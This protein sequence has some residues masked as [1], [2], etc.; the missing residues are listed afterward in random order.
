MVSTSASSRINQ[1]RLVATFIKVKSNKF[2]KKSKTRYLVFL[3]WLWGAHF[4]KVMRV[5]IFLMLLVIS[6]IYANSTY[7]QSTKFSL[8]LRNI[9]LGQLFEEIQNQS[10][11]NIFYNDSQVELD[12]KITVKVSESSVEEVLRQAFEGIDLNFYVFEKQI[13]IFPE[14]K[15][16]N[17]KELNKDLPQQKSVSGKVTD[18]SGSPLPGVTVIVKGST[19]GTISDGEGNFVLSNVSEDAILVFSFIGMRTQEIPVAN[20]SS[21]QKVKMKEDA[22][23]IEEV[24]AVGYGTMK[25]SDVTGA[26]SSVS[27]SALMKSEPTNVLRGV[28]GK[29][30]GVQISQQD[31]APG[32]GF[33]VIIRG[34]NSITAGS[35][36]LYIVDGA[37]FTGDMNEIDPNQIESLEVLKDASATAVYGA[38]AA[39]G[40]IIITTK[41]GKSGENKLD[42]QAS[43]GLAKMSRTPGIMS[44]MELL[45]HARNYHTNWYYRNFDSR[46]Q[47]G[48]YRWS[49]RNEDSETHN[50]I[51]E[52]T[53]VAPTSNISANFIHGSENTNYRIGINYL[54]QE[55]ILKRSGFNRQ[56]LDTRIDQ[57]INNKLSGGASLNINTTLSEGATDGWS[58]SGL[59]TKALQTT[60]FLDTDWQRYEDEDDP[61]D[62]FWMNENINALVNDIDQ[63][64]KTTSVRGFLYLR[65]K[66]IK[67]LELYTSYNR[68]LR[69]IKEGKFTPSTTLAGQ[70]LNG[71]ADYYRRENDNW[72]YQTRLNYKKEIGKHKFNF[73]GLFEANAYEDTRWRQRIQNYSDESRGL[74]DMSV[75]KDH[76]LSSNEI[77]ESSMASFLGRLNY[78]IASK[79]LFTASI[80]ADGSSRFGKD[81][82]WGYF[83]SVAL[84]WRVSEEP[85]IKKISVINNLKI[86]GSYGVVGN[87]QIPSYSSLAMMRTNGYTFNEDNVKGREPSNCAN[88][89][90]GWESTK[91]T[92]FGFDLSLLDSRINFVFEMYNKNTSDM[93]LDVQLPSSSGYSSAIMNIGKLRNRGL[94]FTVNTLN[95]NKKLRWS[96]DITFSLN[97]SKVIDLG[98]PT[99]M[100][101]NRGNIT[102]GSAN[103]ILVKEGYPIGVIVGYIE[104]GIY[105]NEVEIENSPEATTYAPDLGD[106]KFVDINNDGIIN[107][108]DKVPIGY[109]APEFIGGINNMF[110]YKNFDLSIAMRYSYGNDIINPNT[111]Q[112]TRA[113]PSTN[114]LSILSN[115]FWNPLDPDN[116][117]KVD[118]PA[119]GFVVSSM[120]EDG[121]YL[122]CDNIV[123]GYTIPKSVLNRIN[124][125]KMRFYFNV[126]N[127]F[128]ITRYSWYDPEANTSYGTV[129]K[130]GFGIDMGAY[131]R[132]TTYTFGVNLAF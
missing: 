94:E 84:G 27:S 26:I 34:S 40:V 99:E 102:N 113:D 3:K 5:T 74:D 68:Y 44:A 103:E 81:R 37:E 117:L 17:V 9:T 42:V 127:P 33:D 109:T 69:Y 65:Y 114:K 61:D 110:E 22:I 123:L 41:S 121:S 105:N 48:L 104:G 87:N 46:N 119:S 60:P 6:N 29:V 96:T 73:L 108:Y 51:E 116:N 23:N 124:I 125:K 11:F 86:R 57:K 4:F 120:V 13:V 122:K 118:Y 50:W 10:E 132:A 98:E 52:I 111:A 112:L 64:T 72:S 97:R 129:G 66:I 91:Q 85:F 90:L 130:L 19:K 62:F 21:L 14:T 93:L 54:D 36:P 100:Y 1:H 8:N 70:S 101:F 20:K 7:S 24:V 92:N 75:A 107:D 2:M 31:G 30:A 28:S 88:N 56:S 63:E 45:E 67:D 43:Y 55:G 95:L 115:K 131:P 38:R 126:S 15:E 78:S 35:S 82:K 79:Y 18:S 16:K 83:P 39:N 80:R 49:M 89:E 58:Y 25:K 106:S 53:R 47:N 32:G 76:L 12:R 77:S 59:I 128:M 71:Y